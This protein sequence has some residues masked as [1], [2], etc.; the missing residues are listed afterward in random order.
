MAFDRI[1]ITILILLVF[2]QWDPPS[3]SEYPTLCII[4]PIVP[5]NNLVFEFC[6]VC[7]FFLCTKTAN[8]VQYIIAFV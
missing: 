7:I 2:P 4:L 3:P 1:I 6:I 8:T 5:G